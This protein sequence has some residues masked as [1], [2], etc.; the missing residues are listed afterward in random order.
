MKALIINGSSRKTMNTAKLL[1]EAAKGAESAGAQ[2]EIV[3]LYD[4]AFTGCKSCMACKLK[5]T[6]F[7]GR[8]MIKDDLTPVL[9]KCAEAD[10]VI[11]GSPVYFSYPTGEFRSFLE[12][13]LFP[14]HSYQCEV[15]GDPTSTRIKVFEGIKHCGIIWTMNCREDLVGRMKYRE[16]LA[17][18]REFIERLYGYCED[19]WCYNTL[20]V[21]DYSLY[22]M[23][24]IDPNRKAKMYAEQF[25]KDLQAAFDMGRRLA[26]RASA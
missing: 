13:F 19:L 11:M 24:A 15:A 5:N 21:N 1:A 9:D 7:P 4:I 26:E 12:R 18:N 10:V 25:P 3:N 8:C 23:N 6:K 14:V 2:P 22:N 20:Q 17:P 16:V